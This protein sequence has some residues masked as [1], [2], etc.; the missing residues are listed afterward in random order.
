MPI[1]IYPPSTEDF[2]TN[3]LGILQPI[4]C[5]IEEEAAGKYELELVHPID[6][7]QRWAQIQNGC[8]IKAPAPVRE[9]PLYEISQDITEGESVMV[10]RKVYKTNTS[11][12]YLRKEPKVNTTKLTS[13]PVGTEVV[14]LEHTS[15]EKWAK[16]TKIKGGEVGYC[17]FGGLTYVREQDEVITEAKVVGQR[18]VQVQQSREQLF[19]IYSVEQDTESATVTAKA[20]HIFY[21]LRGNIINDEY[22]PENVEVGTAIKDI[23]SKLL[24]SNPFTFHADRIGG[25]VTADYGFKTPVEALLDPDEGIVKQTNAMFVRDNFDIFLLPDSARDMGVTIRRGKNLIGVTVTT[26]DSDV[27]T[28]IVPVGKDKEGEPLYIDARYIDSS[29][30]N[31]YPFIRARRIEY[32]V[33]IGDPDDDNKDKVFKTAKEAK[34]EL[35]RRAQQDFENGCDLPTYGMEV[36]FV[37]LQNTAEYANYASLQAVHLYD[38]ATVIDSM[39]GMKA[40][41]RVTG[42]KWDALAKQY[43]SIKLGDLVDVKQTV[44]SFNLPN[45]GVSGNKIA[46]NSMPGAALRNLSVDYAKITAA[47]IE[48]LSA[49]AITALTAHINEIVSNKITTDELYAAYAELIALKVGTITAGNIKTDALAAELARITVL[50]AGTASFDRATIQHLV[51]E[52]MNLQYGVAGQVFIKNLAVE[53]AQMVGAAIGELCIKAS[54]GNYYLLDVKPDGTVSATPTNV[55]EGEITAGQT[56][57]GQLILETNITAGNLNAGNLLATYALI[58][59]IDAARIDVDELFAREAFIAALT[60]SKIF[61]GNSLEII[62][63][64]AE[65]ASRIFRQEEYPGADETVKPG[66]MLVKPSTGQQ[67]Q[68]VK[69]GDISFALDADGNLYYS[70]DG[71]GSLKMQGFDLYAEDFTLPV[72]ESGSVIG[73]PYKWMLVQDKLMAEAIAAQA[74]EMAEAVL[75]LNKDIAN[76]QDQIDGNIT[77]WFEAYVPTNSNYPANEWTTEELKN[78]HLGDLFYVENPDIAENGY[79]YRWQQTNGVYGWVLLE[80][81]GVAKALAAAAAAQDTADSKRRVFYTTPIPP[82]DAGDLWVQGSGGDI[83]RC[84]AAK[85]SGQSYAAADWVKASKYTDDTIAN[86]ALNKSIYDSATPPAAAPAAGKLWLDRS[87]VPP[88]LRRWL[89]LSLLPDDLDGWETV[90]D[91]ATIEAAQA[92]LDAQQKQSETAIKELQTVVRIDTQGVHVGKAGSDSG[93]V[94][95]ENDRVRIV[96]RGK[97]YATYAGDYMILGG[98]VE[99]RR[100]ASGGLAIGP[101]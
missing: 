29:R 35:E 72:D 11:R 97:A 93:E 58:N 4:E 27:I 83:M 21:D 89:G 55:T 48:Q 44:Y 56:G 73:V 28:R 67:Y 71:S 9:S 38:T 76:L 80:D 95:I 26:D 51:A 8:I 81:S 15:G 69:T 74:A 75:A 12:M 52:A 57:G 23:N 6:S 100:P 47:A 101:V 32:D 63:G 30:I 42:Y 70:Y 41:V 37:L 94:L 98:D 40:K 92:A 54:D 62:A 77:T 82:Y 20:M 7:T 31:D 22:A 46:N 34:A 2:S 3:G 61:G 99:L 87:V 17:P 24:N 39:I 19:R 84:A 18:V 43:E 65:N 78:Q 88:V 86:E 14:L 49:K 64:R 50:I 68:A 90:N 53:Y 5:T 79:C 85:A 60:T 66:D 16:V 45:K 96:V 91:T 13:L 1:C 59:Q 33:S 25:K 36:D 10:K